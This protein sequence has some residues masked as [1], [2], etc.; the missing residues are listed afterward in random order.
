MLPFPLFGMI[1]D[2][3]LDSV[4]EGDAHWRE[5]SIK[6]NR[7]FKIRTKDHIDYSGFSQGGSVGQDTPSKQI[8]MC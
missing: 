7:K 8:L 2:V 3:V 6:W 4:E 1:F 5:M